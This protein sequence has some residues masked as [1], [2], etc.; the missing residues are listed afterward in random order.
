MGRTERECDACELPFL[1]AR[2]AGRLKRYGRGESEVCPHEKGGGSTRLLAL[3][4]PRLPADVLGGVLDS[5]AGFLDVAPGLLA[6]ALGLLGLALGLQRPV[7]G[8][9]AHRL[10]DLAPGLVQLPAGLVS[11]A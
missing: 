8:G 9:P 4:L 10:L 3:R 6:L 2:G 11:G 5:L 1:S 7:L